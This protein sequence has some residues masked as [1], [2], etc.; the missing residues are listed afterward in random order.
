MCDNVS[1]KL[2]TLETK[3]QFEKNINSF[4]LIDIRQYLDVNL[5]YRKTGPGNNQIELI[6]KKSGEKEE[7]PGSMYPPV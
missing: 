3:V 4:D 6:E 7:V 2:T 1:I 5:E